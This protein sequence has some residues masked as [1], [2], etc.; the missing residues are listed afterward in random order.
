MVTAEA[1]TLAD[2]L[3][4]IRELKTLVQKQAEEIADL[5]KE[6]AAAGAETGVLKEGNLLPV[7]LSPMQTSGYLHPTSHAR[8][9]GGRKN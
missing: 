8:F 1:A 6:L 3:A 7:R 5:K 9:A 4:A 2:A